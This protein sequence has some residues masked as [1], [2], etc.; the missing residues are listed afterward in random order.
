MAENLHEGH[1]ERV[2][3]K[4]LAEGF[5]EHTP[6]HEVL[7]MLL[8]YSIPRGNTNE[9][10]HLLVKKFGT[11]ANVL[12]A[13][14]EE[15]LSVKGM[16]KHSVAHFKL[17]LDVVHRYQEDLSSKATVFT[18]A[19][20]IGT[21]LLGRFAGVST[22]RLAVLSL[23]AN[24]RMISFDIISDGTC[25]TIG[26]RARDVL[27]VIMRTKGKAIVLAH[28]HPG[29]LALPSKQDVVSTINVKRL[30]RNAGVVLLDHVVIADGDYVSM[31]QS[32]EFHHIFVD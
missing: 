7:E 19:E 21:Y 32:K 12:N 17:I 15:L 4:F 24:G 2:R 30:L 6:V 25:E 10:A 22:E 9:T 13:S 3:N 16:G 8:F 29:G 18:T 31:V 28:N 27:Q 11:L 1:R 5:S 14:E 20:E 23:N 26:I